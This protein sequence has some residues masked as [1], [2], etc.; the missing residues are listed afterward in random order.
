MNFDEIITEINKKSGD[1]EPIIIGIDGFG[2]SGKST[3]ATRLKAGL[4]DAAIIRFDDFIIGLDVSDEDKSNFD[5][6]RLERE[7]LIPARAG[8][9]IAYRQTRLKGNKLGG[10]IRIPTTKYL[11]IEGVSCYYPSIEKYYDVKIWIDVPANVARD[12][13]AKRD[14]RL[15]LTDIN[16]AGNTELWDMWTKTYQQ[17]KDKH[18]PHERADIIYE[19]YK[20]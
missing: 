12:R 10:T 11:I 16:F 9:P 8:L 18:R 4:K 2:G 5:R 14:K 15:A 3:F 17:Y 7:V 20:S 13:G 6:D 1:T 19:S